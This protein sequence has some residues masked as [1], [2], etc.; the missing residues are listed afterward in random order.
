MENDE[1]TSAHLAL[2]LSLQVAH[3]KVPKLAG[4]LTSTGF[5]A[6]NSW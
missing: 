5:L 6:L 4:P 3:L 2:G 1:H